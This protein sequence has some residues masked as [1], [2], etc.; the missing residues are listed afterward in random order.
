[1]CSFRCPNR[2]RSS[3]SLCMRSLC[4]TSSSSTLVCMSTV[5]LSAPCCVSASSS[6]RCGPTYSA[7]EQLLPRTSDEG[8]LV[9]TSVVVGSCVSLLC[10]YIYIFIFIYIYTLRTGNDS[11]QGDILGLIFYAQLLFLCLTLAACVFRVTL[12]H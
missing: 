4:W 2:P 11:K 9:V 10:N 12:M 5:S 3:W 8:R 6:S 7:A 1:M